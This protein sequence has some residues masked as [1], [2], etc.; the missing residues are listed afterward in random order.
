VGS[1]RGGVNLAAAG[2]VV[3]GAVGFVAFE[4]AIRNKRPT[5][6]DSNPTLATIG[7]G[8]AL[9]LVNNL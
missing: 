2:L 7:A 6:R 3:S 9:A 1:A 8:V 4:Y 5:P